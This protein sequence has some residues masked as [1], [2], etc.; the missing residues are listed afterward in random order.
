[1][2]MSWFC[3]VSFGLL[4]LGCGEGEGTVRVT[5]YGEP[6]I[7]EGI[8]AEAMDDGWAV[9]FQRFAVALRDVR[10]A[11][12]PV[13]I[14]AVIDV[15]EPSAG[16]GHEYGSTPMREGEYGNGSFAIERI[17]VEGTA[18]LGAVTKTFDWE[19]TAATA[20]DACQAT[21]TVPDGGVGTFQV[22]IHADHLF[23]DSLVSEDPAVL[24]QPLAETDTDAD[25]QI[26]QTELTAAGIGAFDPG[27]EGGVQNLWDWLVAAT[28]TI[29]HVDGEGHCDTAPL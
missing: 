17:A 18:N 25:G 5:A 12:V 10:V 11:G 24:F 22:T 6:F 15:S 20:Y 13:G 9:S 8:P 23:Y 2:Q 3:A 16:A 1:M 26:T 7:E 29:G 4:A 21:T 14:P 19:F 27:S 28:R